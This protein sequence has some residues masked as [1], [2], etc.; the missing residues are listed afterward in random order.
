MNGNEMERVNEWNKPTTL[1]QMRERSG[2][3]LSPRAGRTIAPPPTGS[4]RKRWD[5]R[6]APDRVAPPV[7]LIP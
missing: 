3:T 4:D 2:G 5:Y 7:T 1:G 6:Q